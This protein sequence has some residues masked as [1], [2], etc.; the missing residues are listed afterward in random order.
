MDDA[1]STPQI[2]IVGLGPGSLSL[3]TREAEETLLAADRV[4]FRTVHPACDWLRERG[5]PVYCFNLLYD[6]PRI[7]Y[8]DVYAFIVQVV[9]REAEVRGRAVY[10]VPGHPFVLEH[11]AL[12]LADRARSLGFRLQVV[13]GM[14]YIDLVCTE[15]RLDPTSG[16]QLCDALD[17]VGRE[18]NVTA[19]AG[20]LIA[21]LSVRDAL[22]APEG[23]GVV[24]RVAAWLA[25]RFPPEHAVSLVWTTRRPEYATRSRT[26]PLRD[27]VRVCADLKE[28]GFAPTAYVPPASGASGLSTR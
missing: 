13:S 5:R 28:A 19:H 7:T 20:L 10:A 12:M 1:S 3:M 24:E 23:G 22:A 8:E 4:L 16:L 2:V 25:G 9:V 26:V 15:L 18:P 11:S 6:T 21:Q 14:S 27:L 17:F